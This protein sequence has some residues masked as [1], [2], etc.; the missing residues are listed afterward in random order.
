MSGAIGGAPLGATPIGGDW[1]DPLYEQL[2]SI[3]DPDDAEHI[4]HA[5]REDCDYF[6]TLDE[7][8]ILKRA[9]AHT[10][11]VTALCRKLKFVSPQDLAVELRPQE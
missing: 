11:A 9:R 5:V 7:E 10:S 8:S 1:T 4:V 2:S 3:F 6:L